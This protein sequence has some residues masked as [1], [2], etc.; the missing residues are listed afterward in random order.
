MS[1]AAPRAARYSVLIA[2]FNAA[3]TLPA[4]LDSALAQTLPEWEAIVVDD[5]SSDDTP[6]IARAYAESDARIRFVSQDNRG[7]AGARNTAA[8]LARAPYLCVLDA[9]DEYRPEYLASMDRF[10][11]GHPGCAV[12]SCNPL[13][14]DDS[15]ELVPFRPD[16]YPRAEASLTLAEMIA[17]DRIFTCAVVDAEAFRAAGGYTEDSYVENYDLWLRLLA[18]GGTHAHNPEHLAVYGLLGE[19]MTDREEKQV[20]AAAEALRR[21]A[22]K[23]SLPAETRRAASESAA[24]L[25]RR[26]RSLRG[27][28]ARHAFE[29]RLAAGDFAHARRDYRGTRDGFAHGSRY[30][31]GLALVTLSPRLLAWALRRAG[32]SGDPS[33]TGIRA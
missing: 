17:A 4:T 16:L 22:A 7:C 24:A 21:L 8:E 30:L 9:D 29:A 20:D 15:G 12:Y 28:D 2:A 27:A 18:A 23:E 32:D 5:G 6:T 11:H 19:R 31:L 1:E 14:R 25:S 10:I 26:A 33:V 13:F 3:A